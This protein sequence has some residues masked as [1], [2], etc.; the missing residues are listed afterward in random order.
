MGMNAA[1]DEVA[2]AADEVAAD[3][4]EVA[5][6]AREM[7]RRRDAGWSWAQILDWDPDP[8]ILGLLRR[9]GR[10][11][12]EAVGGL[13]SAAASGLSSE[14]ETHRQIARRLG[15]SHQRVT[16]MLKEDRRLPDRSRLTVGNR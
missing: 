15:V 7:Q 3:Q 1:L 16:A 5:R 11:M 14:G 12:A 8:G 2:A 10:R 13:A 6:R 9:S 4:R